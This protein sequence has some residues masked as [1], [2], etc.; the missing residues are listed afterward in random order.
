MGGPWGENSVE[1]K[2]A[3]E[4]SQEVTKKVELGPREGRSSGGLQLEETDSKLG[5]QECPPMLST[6]LCSGET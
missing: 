4:G 6:H 3:V 2:G 5:S 1:M